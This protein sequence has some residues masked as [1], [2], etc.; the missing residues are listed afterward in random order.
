[1]RSPCLKP[2]MVLEGS[3]RPL[4]VFTERLVLFNVILHSVISFAG[5]PSLEIAAIRHPL[6][7]HGMLPCSR[8]KGDKCRL[9]SHS[10]SLRFDAV[11]YLGNGEFPRFENALRTVQYTSST[12]VRT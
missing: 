7:H 11:V 8:Q 6:L 3:K 1:M 10:S 5:L 9:D 4:P 12:L 2:Y